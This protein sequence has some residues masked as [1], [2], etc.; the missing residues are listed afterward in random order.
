MIYGSRTYY[1]PGQ[2][3]VNCDVCGFKFK[4]DEIKKRWDGLMVCPADYEADHPQKY[5]RVHEDKISV[6]YVRKMSD[7]TFI[8]VCTAWTQ[9]AYADV[10]T[11]DCAQADNARYPYQITMT[12]SLF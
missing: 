11:A 5:L 4:S 8:A 10:G 3:N 7:D 6:P 2:W 12:G 9:L 1:K